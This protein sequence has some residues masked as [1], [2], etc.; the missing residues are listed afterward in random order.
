MFRYVLRL[1]IRC[2]GPWLTVDARIF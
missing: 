1:N 2:R